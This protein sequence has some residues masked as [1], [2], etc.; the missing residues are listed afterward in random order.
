[1]PIRDWNRT[2]KDSKTIDLV[3]KEEFLLNNIYDCK[4]VFVTSDGNVIL[5]TCTYPNGDI[6]TGEYENGTRHGYGIYKY[7]DGDIYKGYWENDKLQDIEQNQYQEKRDAQPLNQ[8]LSA[9]KN[10]K[11][12]LIDEEE[13]KS[14]KEFASPK[15]NLDGKN[16]STSLKPSS[17]PHTDVALGGMKF[18]SKDNSTKKPILVIKKRDI[19]KLEQSLGPNL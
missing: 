8:S 15:L 6:Y 11:L 7:A 9:A 19:V 4:N 1:M 3:F 2:D 14:E 12:E 13:K 10:P 5:G 18:V 17:T 16:L